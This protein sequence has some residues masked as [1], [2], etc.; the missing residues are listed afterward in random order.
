MNKTF[1]LIN[2]SSEKPIRIYNS[3]R[4]L[5]LIPPGFHAATVLL[6]GTLQSDL[7]WKQGSESA[8]KFM[9]QGLKIFWELD[10]GLFAKLQEPLSDQMQFQA[11]QISL[12][13]FRDTVWKEFEHHTVGISIFIG[14]TDFAKQMKWNN[15]QIDN[16]QLWLKE[17]YQTPEKLSEQLEGLV[18][19]FQ[20]I[21]P[22]LLQQTVF[23]KSLLKLF[24]RNAFFEYAELLARSLPPE[25]PV[26][27]LF[28]PSPTQDIYLLA[29]MIAQDNFDS[30][31]FG[32]TTPNYPIYTFTNHIQAIL[33]SHMTYDIPVQKPTTAIC[34]PPQQ[35]FNKENYISFHEIIDDLKQQNTQF[36]IIP[37]NTLTTSWEGIDTLIILPDSVT[38][39]G[40]RK[41]QGFTAA[42]GK[43]QAYV[44]TC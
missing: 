17:L 21:Q 5:E 33:E 26:Y 10:L 13:H 12:K 6:D 42:S 9:A 18:K 25:I 37:E 16:L 14:T 36:R 2:E 28:D 41:L 34:L 44:N 4:V 27:L 43:I 20:D 15:D 29:N 23:G 38:P 30:L 3:K 1:Y 35:F 22:D 11:L 7:N 32:I 24:C 40:K 39:Q 19:S 31:H 8:K